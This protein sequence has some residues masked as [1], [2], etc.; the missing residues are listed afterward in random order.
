LI[1]RS[2]QTNS[3][4]GGDGGH[5]GDGG[6]GP[7]GN[8]GDGEG[9]GIWM[10]SGTT[11]LTRVEAYTNA[12]S[13]GVG[14]AG[15]EGGH[16]SNQTGGAGGNGGE[17]V[18]GGIYHKRRKPHRQQSEVHVQHTRS[19]QRAAAAEQVSTAPAVAVE[20]AAK[21]WAAPIYDAHKLRFNFVRNVHIQLRVRTL[22]R[23]RVE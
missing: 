6:T 21:R 7:G 12:A 2:S 16:G 8:G 4:T 15:G 10:Q 19:A 18:G 9:A 3:G 20:T 23:R 1:A 14:G 5:G 17:G 13:G 11:T 22:R